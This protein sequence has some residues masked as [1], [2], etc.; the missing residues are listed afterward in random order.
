MESRTQSGVKFNDAKH[1]CGE[2][3]ARTAGNDR[4]LMFRVD[5]RASIL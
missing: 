1:F 5:R 3:A 2:D 4:C